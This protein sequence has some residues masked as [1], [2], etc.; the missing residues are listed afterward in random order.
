MVVDYY[1]YF[2]SINYPNLK[3]GAQKNKSV[4]SVRVENNRIR[5]EFDYSDVAKAAEF[6]GA[7]ARKGKHV[8]WIQL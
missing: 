4:Q 1:S 7:L 2:R 8:A 3:G 5:M 6:C